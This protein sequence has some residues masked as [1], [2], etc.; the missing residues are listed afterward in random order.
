MYNL[1]VPSWRYSYKQVPLNSLQ[2]PTV[3]ILHLNF[4]GNCSFLCMLL[5]I[6]TRYCTIRADI[7]FVKIIII[8]LYFF[9]NRRQPAIAHQF[10]R[11]HVAGCL[12]HWITA[13]TRR[14]P[15]RINIGNDPDQTSDKRL[16]RVSRCETS[17]R[18]ASKLSWSY[19]RIIMLGFFFR[20]VICGMQVCEFM[21]NKNYII[22]LY[23]T[24]FV[25][26]IY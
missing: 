6:P 1:S 10:H 7:C 5:R 9:D 23:F 15:L 12:P 18:V 22:F 4:G 3:T 25:I 26:E 13:T 20:E 19:L 21:I 11:R 17:T 24:N 16:R 2:N 14:A 8:F